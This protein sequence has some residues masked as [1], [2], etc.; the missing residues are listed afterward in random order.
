MVR[1]SIFLS[2][3]ALALTACDPILKT[4]TY[5]QAVSRCQEESREASSPQ[6]SATV[7]ANSNTGLFGGLSISLS[8]AYIRGLDPAMVYETC[9]NDLAANGQI[10]G[11]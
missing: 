11:G 10:I 5:S 8:D 6:I 4:M 3:A 7:G 1:M 2:V 9:M